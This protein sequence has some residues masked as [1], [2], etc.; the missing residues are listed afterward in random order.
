VSKSSTNESVENVIETRATIFVSASLPQNP[1]NVYHPND[2]CVTSLYSK[3]EMFGQNRPT[4]G[5]TSGTGFGKYNI[6]QNCFL[7]TN[8][9]QTCQ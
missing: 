8:L 7:V 9:V 1:P 5:A 4:F 6:F 2:L 3:E